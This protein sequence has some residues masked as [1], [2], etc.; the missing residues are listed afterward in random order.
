MKYKN[1]NTFLEIF[2]KILSTYLKFM[3]LNSAF[4]INVSLSSTLKTQ[5]YK[6]KNKVLSLVMILPINQVDNFL[7]CVKYILYLNINTY[8]IKNYL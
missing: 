7:L 3:S 8:L 2:K 5:Q 1:K 4:T 6:K